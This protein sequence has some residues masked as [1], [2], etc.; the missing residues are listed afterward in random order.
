MC[1]QTITGCSRCGPVT[2]DVCCD[3]HH[4]FAFPLFDTLVPQPPKLPN[5]SRLPNYSMG[6]KEYELCEALEDWREE[7][8]AEKYGRSHLIDIGPSIIM[9]DSILDRLVNC[10]HHEKIKT[11]ED[12]RKETHWLA[13]DKYEPEVLAIIHRIIPVKVVS[14]ALTNTPLQRRP[15]STVANPPRGGNVALPSTV[16]AVKKTNRCS[17]C[18]QE[19]HNSMYCYT[20]CSTSSGLT[21]SPERNRICLLHPTHNATHTSTTD[22]ENVRVFTQSSCP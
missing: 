11:I 6:P 15:L 19:G 7:K 12:F 3:I 17:A 9:S 2:P 21:C 1:D 5:R 14:V 4:P 10:A 22:K 8:M 18:Q 13:T 16:S 20:L